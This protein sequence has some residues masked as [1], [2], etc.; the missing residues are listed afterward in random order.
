V[1]LLFCVDL[2]VQVGV[3][4]SCLFKTVTVRCGHCANLLSVNLRGLL[5]PPAASPANQ[6]NFGGQ[7]SLLSPTSPQGLLVCITHQPT[8]LISPNNVITLASSSSIQ[9]LSKLNSVTVYL[10]FSRAGRV[11][12]SAAEPP[13]GTSERQPKQHHRPQLQQLR[14]QRACRA[15]AAG[16]EA[17][18]ARAGAANKECS[19]GE[20]T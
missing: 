6:L 5:L 4:C 8:R 1:T 20:P 12:A 16:G 17:R 14:Q 15:D 10:V 9:V 13:D 18:A 3:P 11:G 7:S 19:V 2:G